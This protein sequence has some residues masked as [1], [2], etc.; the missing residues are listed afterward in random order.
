[1]S[2]DASPVLSV[3]IVS[4]NTRQMTLACLR[5]VYRGLGALP[6]DVWVVDNA[7]TD[8]TPA[9][10]AKEF[11]E[12]RLI[13]NPS[14]VGFGAA[15][16]QAIQA[17]CSEFVLLLNSDAFPDRRAVPLLVE[18][19]RA[20][21]DTAAVGPRLV[22]A[23]GSLQRSCYRLPS[24]LRA[25]WENL[26]LTAALPD[27]RIFGDYRAWSHDSARNVE[28]VIG[29][30]LLLR[31]SALERVG[32]FDERFFL[33]AEETDLCLRLRRAGYQ[34]RFLPSAVVVHLNGGSG[35]RQPDRVFCEFRRSQEKFYAKHYGVAGLWCHRA[36][37]LVGSLLRIVLFTVLGA[38]SRIRRVRYREEAATW[39]RILAWT[40]GLRG[41]G[42]SD[43]TTGAAP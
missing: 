43:R 14:N 40:A 32:P 34:I 6:A 7:S 36:T 1:M 33:Y 10:V 17:S 25:I 9:A 41:P 18:F 22:N 38:V 30:C 3:I 15:N 20:H 21:P 12:V 19:L 37:M 35:T 13:T 42:L 29:A 4:Y 2:R 8:G 23:D 39:K 16:N 28:M 26:L 31:R 24:P 11:P 5:S 27:H